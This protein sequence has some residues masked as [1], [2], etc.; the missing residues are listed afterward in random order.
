MAYPA[1]QRQHQAPHTRS[2]YPILENVE[3]SP[4][5]DDIMESLSTQQLRHVVIQLQTNNVEL[6]NQLQQ[7]NDM[8]RREQE[9]NDVL[10]TIV[11]A[12]QVRRNK[13]KHSCTQHITDS[14][15]SFLLHSHLHHRHMFVSG[16]DNIIGK[17]K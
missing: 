8:Y 13:T 17:R 4:F 5:S 11:T 12:Q 3:I 14:N 6:I 16:T 9:A 7:L 2:T 1:N 15:D 10:Q